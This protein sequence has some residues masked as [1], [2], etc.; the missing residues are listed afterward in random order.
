MVVVGWGALSHEQV[1]M[2]VL[3]NRGLRVGG[4]MAAVFVHIMVTLLCVQG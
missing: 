2:Q 3:L 1:Q 4:C